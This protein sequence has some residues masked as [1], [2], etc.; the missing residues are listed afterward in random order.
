M[1]QSIGLS[2]IVVT[3]AVLVSAAPARAQS[4]IVGKVIAK[5]KSAIEKV[6]NTCAEDIKTFCPKVV[7]GDGRMAFCFM[8][9]EDQISDKCYFAVMDVIDGVEL[10]VSNVWRAA[11]VCEVD[12]EKHCSG[13]EPGEGRMAQCLIDNQTKLR[14]V[15]RAEV[16]G[17]AARMKK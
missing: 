6:H 9:H 3:C 14:S 7:P 2:L 10:A 15:C 8:A 12:L 1:K 13:V 5:A 4:D 16:A 17:F 11:D